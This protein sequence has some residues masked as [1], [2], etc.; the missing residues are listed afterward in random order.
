MTITPNRPTAATPMRSVTRLAVAALRDGKVV[1]ATDVE[2]RKYRVI[3]TG[4]V[5]AI[6]ELTY[7]GWSTG[8]KKITV[9]S[10]ITQWA[11]DRGFYQTITADAAPGFTFATGLPLKSEAPALHS[12]A[13]RTWLASWGEQVVKPGA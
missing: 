3:S 2:A 12:T 5:R 9:H 1:K 8:D 13:G 10:R 6:V 11:G 4:P 7:E